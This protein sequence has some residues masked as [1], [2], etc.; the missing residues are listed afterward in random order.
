MITKSMGGANRM[1]SRLT[2]PN[3]LYPSTWGSSLAGASV[4]ISQFSVIL[5]LITAGRG[6]NDLLTSAL[7]Y[8]V[9]EA[10]SA[11]TSSCPQLAAQK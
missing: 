5:I 9:P 6:Q 8:S 11:I 4:G 2:L 3:S 7:T 10:F 1:D